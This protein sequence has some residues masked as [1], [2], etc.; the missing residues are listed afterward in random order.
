MTHDLARLPARARPGQRYGYRAHGPYAPRAGHRFN[1]N[2]LLLDPYA[3]AI[4]GP[5]LWERGNTLPYVPGPHPD[6]DLE[7]DDEDD[8]DAIPKSVV[9]DPS[10]E[11]EGDASLDTAVERD[12]RRRAA[13][14]GVHE[15]A[16]RVR[17][18]PARHVRRPRLRSR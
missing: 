16:P 12:R 15:A 2:K 11:W 8:A 1:A 14:Q 17:D 13:R 7:A 10:F 3:K 9:I 4:E 18:E 6:V 5:V